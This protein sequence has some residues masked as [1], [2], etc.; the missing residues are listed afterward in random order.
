[1]NRS[2]NDLLEDIVRCHGK[3]LYNLAYRICGDEVMAEDLLQESLLNIYEALPQFE[4]RSSIYTWAYKITLRTCL[5]RNSRDRNRRDAERSLMKKDADNQEEIILADTAGINPDDDLVEKALITEVREKCHY[6]ML[7]K[8]TDEQ[9]ATILLK[10]LFDFSYSDIAYILNVNE[11]TVKSRIFRARSNLKRHFEK[12]CS[13]INPDNPCKC[14]TMAGYT[15]LK[16]PSLL[17]RLSLRT[18][19]DEYN[20][21]IARQINKDIKTEADIIST[22]PLLDFKGKKALENFYKKVK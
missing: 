2:I 22:F 5:N 18:E 12:K 21:M 8:L 9:R 4:E 3:Q 1:M 14:K 6:F 17:K 7:F 15:V 20:Q 13:W 11:T 10:D 16:Y 19:R